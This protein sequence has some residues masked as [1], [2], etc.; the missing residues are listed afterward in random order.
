MKQVPFFSEYHKFGVIFI[1][2][3]NLNLS[4]AQER[5]KIHQDSISQWAD[6][7]PEFRNSVHDKDYQG[8]QISGVIR[9]VFED[10]KGNFWFGTQN[11]LCRYDGK[12]LMYFDLRD[13]NN[14]ETVAYDIVEDN[15]NIIWIALDGL[16]AKFD[17]TYFTS[18]FDEH[19]LTTSSLWCL[20][21][22]K[23]GLIWLGT[24]TGVY[25]F[26]GTEFTPFELPEGKVDPSRGISTPKMIHNILEDSKGDM[27]FATNAG[28]FR[29]DGSK[30]TQFSE[31][32]GLGSNFVSTLIEDKK[33]HFWFG[34]TRNE[35]CYYDGNTI[36]NIS[37]EFELFGKG[38]G[39]IMEDKNGDIWFAVQG[40]GVFVYDGTKIHPAGNGIFSQ[41]TFRIYQDREDRIWFVGFKGAYR[42]DGKEFVNVTRDGP[43]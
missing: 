21:A 18:Y 28:A 11:G 15:F 25:T 13:R 14:R 1:F 30:L 35:L 39:N 3:L 43:W 34:T 2:L 38:A 42:Y 5:T 4:W 26:D 33:G 10:S 37:E 22:D 17:G 23:N 29:Y 8:N 36:K 32:D 6:T 31:K 24:T 40:K 27:W 12:K 20:E 9:V 41:T 16:L 19:I 7:L